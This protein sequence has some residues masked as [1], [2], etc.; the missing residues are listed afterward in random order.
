MNKKILFGRSLKDILIAFAPSLVILTIVFLVA[1]RYVN[2]QPPDHIVISTGDGE[3]DYQAYAEAYRDIIKQ[4]GIKLV[5]RPSTGA[6]ENLRLLT[7]P[8]SDIDVAFVQD[9]LEAKEE[10]DSPYDLVSLGSLYYEP[11][12]IFYRGKKELTRVSQLKGKKLA[13]GEHGGGTPALAAKILEESGIGKDDAEIVS[14][15]FRG[16]ADALKKGE[17]DAAFFLATPE[18]ELI[19]ELLA[20]KSLHVMNLDQAE[21]IT[22]K[23]PYLHH[24][25]VPHGSIDL[26]KNLPDQDLN[27]VSTTATLVARDT[28]HPALVDLL[29]KAATEVHG[30]PSTLE[31]KGEFPIDKDYNFPMSAE[32]K[33]Y[34]K[35]G[36]PF[37]QRYLPFWLANLVDRFILIVLPLL[38]VIIPMLKTIPQIMDWRVRRR[39]HRAYG[40][41]KFLE[42]QLRNETTHEKYRAHLRELDRIEDRVRALRVPIHFSEH[43]FGLRGNIEF[44]RGKLANGLEHQDKAS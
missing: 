21:G 35:V 1:R 7:D 3:G 22:R 40:E 29:L 18:E 30:E 32:A 20:E 6:R 19:K 44:V 27:L 25:T 34:F 33:R 12:W 17:V 36:A 10:K 38:A 28:I 43:I 31:R 14:L 24:L 37:W 5:I 11:M 23:I 4:D 42:T 41:L 2:P 26:A 13:I 9:G 39:I 8:K 15:D 16:S